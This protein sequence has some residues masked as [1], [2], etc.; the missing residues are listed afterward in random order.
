MVQI[1]W[2][3]DRMGLIVKRNS[4]VGGARIRKEVLAKANILL[5]AKSF[6]FTVFSIFSDFGAEAIR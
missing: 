3:I 4:M 1:W 6:H 5:R 2:F